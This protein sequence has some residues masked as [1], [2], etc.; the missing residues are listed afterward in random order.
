MAPETEDDRLIVAAGQ[1][2]ERAFNRL[3]AAHAPRV[4]AVA[5]RYLASN[6]DAEDVAQEVFWRVWRSASSWRPGGAQFS[7]FLYRVTVNICIDRA[8]RR[9]RNVP[10]EEADEIA[11]AG[12]SA[13]GSLADRQILGAMRKAIAALP[14]RQ[15]IAIILS[16]QQ[17]L[18]TREIA[19]AMK[20]SEGAVEQLLVRARRSLKERYGEL[21]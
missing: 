9:R 4:H 7:T 2:D 20:I 18:A 11:D 12:A 16:V 15:R 14:E 19:A 17:Q 8:R 3:V 1:G 5:R 6:A 13:E 10:V 21:T